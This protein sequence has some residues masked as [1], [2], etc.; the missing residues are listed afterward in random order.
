MGS[1]MQHL[2]KLCDS[3]QIFYGF[4]GTYVVLSLQS[5]RQDDSNDN[6]TYVL[7]EKADY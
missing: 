5:S 6:T 3:F 1:D 2:T 4:M 7:V